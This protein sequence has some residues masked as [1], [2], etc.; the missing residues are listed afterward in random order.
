M[1]RNE[2]HSRPKEWL[3]TLSDCNQMLIFTKTHLYM[4]GTIEAVVTPTNLPAPF[5]KPLSV[6]E[7]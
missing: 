5:M 7:G 3:N 2:A 4:Q 1:N 6:R